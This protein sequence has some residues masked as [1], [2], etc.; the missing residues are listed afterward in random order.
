MLGERPLR[1]NVFDHY[2]ERHSFIHQLDPRTKVILTFGYILSIVLVPDGAWLGFFLAWILLVA[3]TL[4]ARLK[5]TF[6]LMRAFVVI[7]FMLAAIPL[8]F[9]TQ[10]EPLIGSSILGWDWVVTDTGLIRFVSIVI[11]SLLSVQMAVLLTGTTRFPDIL[12]ALRHL[13]VPNVLVTVTAFMYRYLFVLVDEATRLI[14]GRQSRSA[15][16]KDQSGGLS[17][18]QKARVTGN[19]VGQLFIRSIER[20]ER[21]YNAMVARG[22]RDQFLTINPHTLTRTDWFT[23]MTW[24]ILIVVVHAI[25]Q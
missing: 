4:S 10:G 25:S 5:L 24:L 18:S 7:P 1:I 13:R 20:S 21:V 6:A 14:R 9:S 23:I 16:R 8:L 19:M 12:H 11:R 15:Y 3:M 17:V 22:Y 2:Q